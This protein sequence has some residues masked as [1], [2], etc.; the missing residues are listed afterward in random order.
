M[1]T[2]AIG[3]FLQLAEHRGVD[4]GSQHLLQLGQRMALRVAYLLLRRYLEFCELGVNASRRRR[5]G[6]AAT[7]DVRQ[8]YLSGSYGLL[9]WLRTQSLRQ[10]ARCASWL[11]ID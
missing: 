4:G 9:P 7:L 10:Q 1:I 5:Q 11:L 2:R 8:V 6:R 3:E